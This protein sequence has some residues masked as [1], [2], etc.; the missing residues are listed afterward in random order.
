MFEEKLRPLPE[1]RDCLIM[2]HHLSYQL[3]DESQE[4]TATL[5][6]RGENEKDSAVARVIGYTCGAAA[7]SILSGLVKVKG[8]HIP[9]VREIYDPILN[10]LEEAGI[11]FHITEKK[12]QTAE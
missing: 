4:L 6:L 12:M 9:I 11:A 7:K 2:E 10:E 5:V 8:L 3:R 1:D